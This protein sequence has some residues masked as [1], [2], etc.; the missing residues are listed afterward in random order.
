MGVKCEVWRT[1]LPSHPHPTSER[2]FYCYA[3]R[4]WWGAFPTLPD[5][6]QFNRLVRQPHSGV[7]RLLSLSG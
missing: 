3:Q 2:A 6:R 4:Y 1:H 7:R 5:C